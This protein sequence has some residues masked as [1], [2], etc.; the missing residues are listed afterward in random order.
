MPG[1]SLTRI[2]GRFLLFVDF[3]M[4]IL[5]GFSLDFIRKKLNNA[6]YILVYIAIV[7]ITV[8]DLWWFGYGFNNVIP[9]SYFDPPQSAQF[10]SQDNSLFRYKSLVGRASWK[11]AW[12]NAGGWRG[13]LFPYFIQRETLPPDFNLL[14]RLASSSL[15]YAT[16]GHFGVRSS[17]DIDYFIDALYG[18]RGSVSSNIMAASNIKYLISSLI[19]DNTNEFELVKTI[20]PPKG[21]YYVYIYKNLNWLPRAY[22]VG[23]G[24]NFTNPEDVLGSLLEFDPR[25]EV[26]LLDSPQFQSGGDG[27]VDIESYEPN[28]VRLK[29]NSEKGGFLV[30]SDTFYPGW[31]AYIDGSETPIYRANYTYRAVHLDQ[32]EHKVVFVYDPLSFK[33]GEIISGAALII[34][35]GSGLLFVYLRGHKRL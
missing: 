6:K 18:D 33:L 4:A 29:A 31:K 15:I 30:L 13:D 11:L 19:L 22:F 7:L 21:D 28:K 35:A 14:F 34:I 26:L 17:A 27:T 25:K 23:R 12:K 20:I 1:F 10:L 24:D 32:G 2:P 16:T 3:F 9:V 8:A 5:A